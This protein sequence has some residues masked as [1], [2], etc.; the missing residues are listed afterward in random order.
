MG[1]KQIGRAMINM[2]NMC[3]VPCGLHTLCCMMKIDVEGKPTPDTSWSTYRGRKLTA[4]LEDVQAIA[5]DLESQSGHG[6]CLGDIFR[7]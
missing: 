2:V 5:E 3:Y 7:K 6:W 4:S 1:S